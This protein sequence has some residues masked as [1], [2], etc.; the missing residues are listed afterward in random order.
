MHVLEL[1]KPTQVEETLN[2]TED[3]VH[4]TLSEENL[5]ELV[6]LLLL[7]TLLTLFIP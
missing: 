3:T 4:A 1:M 7:L 6:L 5:M 2:I